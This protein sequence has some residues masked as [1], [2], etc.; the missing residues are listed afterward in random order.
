MPGA[1]GKSPD[2]CSGYLNGSKKEDAGFVSLFLC[3]CGD[4]DAIVVLAECEFALVRHQVTPPAY[5]TTQYLC[6]GGS[7]GFIEAVCLAAPTQAPL[8]IMYL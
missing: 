2:S 5:T 3:L 1:L 6:R 4:P 7:R 8:Q